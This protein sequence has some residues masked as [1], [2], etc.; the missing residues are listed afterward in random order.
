MFWLAANI[1]LLPLNYLVNSSGEGSRS[2]L[3]ECSLHVLL[4]LIHYRKCVDG[5]VF[6]VDGSDDHAASDSSLKRNTCFSQNPY[7]R[8]LE[9]ATDVECK[10]KKIKINKSCHFLW[11]HF[12]I[13]KCECVPCLQLI[14][15]IPRGL[16]KV[17]QFWGYLLHLFLI[18]LECEWI[19]F[20]FYIS[21]WKW[22]LLS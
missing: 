15:W 11:L 20:S 7:C 6:I 12:S 4:V 16:H 21:S 13:M 8:A 2:P 10:G 18:L 22:N 9:N 1:V 19:I 17:V 14:V 5:D 3:A